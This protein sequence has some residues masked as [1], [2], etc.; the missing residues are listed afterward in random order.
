[1]ADAYE[2]EEMP[3]KGEVLFRHKVSS[4]RWLIGLMGAFPLVLGGAGAI[5][6]GVAEGSGVGA[7]VFAGAAA[8]SALMS[9]VMVTFATGRIAVSEGERHLQ[10]G[11][12]GPRI[13][14]E[15]IAS[16]RVA[17]SG[18]NR[19]GMGASNDL[20]G[21]TYYTL[22]GDNA[23]AVHIERTDGSKLV[24]V[25]KEPDAMARAI[26]EAMARTGRG[27][28][29]ARVEVADE[30]EVAEEAVEPARERRAGE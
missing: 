8:L 25:M 10:I 3:G 12:A 14:I 11:F 16:V 20:R 6:A 4:P 21:T 17:P 2:R 30:E 18:I 24:I 23:R 7:G 27:A 29:R 26:E 22:W 1:M 15:E 9:F 19:I 13:P 5:V 28:V